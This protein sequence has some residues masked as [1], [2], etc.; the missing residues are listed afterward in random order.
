MNQDVI[1]FFSSCGLDTCYLCSDAC[2]GDTDLPH[3]G[4]F[5][6]YNSHVFNLVL[7]NIQSLCL[8]QLLCHKTHKRVV[9]SVGCQ[10]QTN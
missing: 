7:L 8:I 4:F 3:V 2:A 9:W 6:I 1:F 10:G 5:A